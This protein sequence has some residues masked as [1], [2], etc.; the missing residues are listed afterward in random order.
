MN[1]MDIHVRFGHY[2]TLDFFIAFAFKYCSKPVGFFKYCSNFFW[3][4]L[5]KDLC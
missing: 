3:Q 1:L 4:R 5:Y 2:L